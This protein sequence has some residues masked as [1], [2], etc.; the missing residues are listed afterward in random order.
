MITRYD[1]GM[2]THPDAT[3]PTTLACEV[4]AR[5]KQWEGGD[6][7]RTLARAVLAVADLADRYEVT[8]REEAA[9]GGNKARADAFAVHLTRIRAALNGDNG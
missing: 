5:N 1:Q 3:D 6:V 8:M 7:A 4:I 9:P 2:N